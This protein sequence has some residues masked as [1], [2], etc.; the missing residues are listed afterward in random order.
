MRTLHRAIRPAKLNHELFAVLK[1]AEVNDCLL[2]C[3]YAVHVVNIGVWSWSVK[4]IITQIRFFRW[5][6]L[7]STSP[8]TSQL[9]G[10]IGT[11]PGGTAESSPGR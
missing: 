10:C 3:L 7:D 11:S 4:Y 5:A 6:D 9:S 8:K 2:K 1:I